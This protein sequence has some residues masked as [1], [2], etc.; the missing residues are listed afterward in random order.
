[1]AGQCEPILTLWASVKLQPSV[2]IGKVCEGLILNMAGQYE[3]QSREYYTVLIE[4]P[5]LSICTVQGLDLANTFERMR[6]GEGEGGGRQNW[7]TNMIHNTPMLEPG[8][9]SCYFMHFCIWYNRSAP[10][11]L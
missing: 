2:H 3:P 11:F 6:R 5:L 4:G 8:C 1:M 9:F 7:Q 10:Y